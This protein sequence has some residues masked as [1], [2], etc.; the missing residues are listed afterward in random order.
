MERKIGNRRRP[1]RGTQIISIISVAL[2]LVILGI[3][4]MTAIVARKSTDEIRSNVGFVIKVN[5]LAS[6]EYI[7]SLKNIIST[8]PYVAEVKYLTAEQVLEEWK[9]RL[10]LN[11]LPDINP[12]LPEYN[13]RVKSQWANIDS[14]N[15]I[16]QQL[17]PLDAV[18]EQVEI[19][20]DI[21]S[22]V[23]M[24]I[25]SVIMALLVVAVA[26]LL[27]SFVLINNTVRMEIYAQRMI[28]YAMQY[29]GATPGFIRRP[30]IV[31]SVLDGVIAAVVASAALMGI[32]I[33]T[34]SQYVAIKACFSVTDLLVVCAMLVMVGAMLC[35][36]ASYLAT[37]KYLHKSQDEIFN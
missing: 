32:I 20:T 6:A 2:V 33:G 28:I 9:P 25:N 23:N 17:E 14:L 35:G 19:H 7:D 11:E 21:V 34:T 36:M 3:V 29:V 5:N 30:Y 18:Y 16:K 26:L 15:I 24:T 13:I 1:A 27:I 31:R 10:E 12:F 8:A 37:T 4:A 22:N